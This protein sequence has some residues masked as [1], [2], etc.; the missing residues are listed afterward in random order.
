MT[1]TTTVQLSPY[2]TGL[3]SWDAASGRF[4]V[5]GAASL[6]VDGKPIGQSRDTTSATGNTSTDSSGNVNLS[7]YGQLSQLLDSF[8]T[9]LKNSTAPVFAA[10]VSDLSIASARITGTVNTASLTGIS[11]S[12]LA[13][14]QKLLSSA[15]DQASSLI[16]YGSLTLAT[17]RYDS[18]SRT[19]TAANSTQIDLPANGASLQTIADAI[20]QSNAAVKATIIQSSSGAQ[21]QLESTQSGAANTIRLT[22]DDRGDGNNSDNNGLSRLA[23][24]PAAA[25]GSGQNLTVSQPAQDAIYSLDGASQTSP[26]NTVQD[27]VAGVTVTLKQAGTFS[28]STTTPFSGILQTANGIVSAYNQYVDS[29]GKLASASPPNAAGGANSQ[30]NKL[31]ND[32][33]KPTDWLNQQQDTLKQYGIGWQ[34]NSG[35]LQLNDSKL[36]S[37]WNANPFA[38]Q[39]GLRD[40]T[41]GLLG[42]A[43]GSLAPDYTFGT[44]A[45]NAVGR[46]YQNNSGA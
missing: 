21:L 38:T 4:G 44:G 3:Y 12:Q 7:L 35:K 27:M 34:D 15:F 11:V 42:I 1:D 39:Q 17:G 36:Y 37:Q 19:F 29:L 31:Q 10:G 41:A 18:S 16:G 25:Q 22:V 43:S 6:A 28:L 5:S 23:F 2:V 32:S 24:D 33:A 20:N 8:H 13:Q 30:A 14:S 40:L 45:Q 46:H 26:S 9:D